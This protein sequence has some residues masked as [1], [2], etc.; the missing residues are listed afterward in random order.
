MGLARFAIDISVIGMVFLQA[1]VT[2][3]NPLQSGEP[4]RPATAETLRLHTSPGHY[5]A[6]VYARPLPGADFLF[7]NDEP[8]SLELRLVNT[9]RQPI[10]LTASQP[11]DLFSLELTLTRADQPRSEQ[12]TD[13]QFSRPPYVTAI[14]A[15]IP[16]VPGSVIPPRMEL[17]IPVSF[18]P[19]H[20]WPSGVL[21]VT[22]DLRLQCEPACELRSGFNVFRFEVRPVNSSLERME[23]AHRKAVRANLARDYDAAEEALRELDSENSNTIYGLYMHA[24]VAERRGVLA[25]ALKYYR[26][27][28]ATFVSGT[29][30]IG[31]SHMGAESDEFL[32]LVRRQIERLQKPK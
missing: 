8:V 16:A 28:E 32:W 2:G 30:P 19:S 5:I 22:A 25:E 24:V 18:K 23:H 15:N 10:R 29:D 21:N 27:A 13:W 14:G 11:E 3:R 12:V 26:L 4:S 17:V 9:S 31:M 20:E 6:D 1:A 7:F